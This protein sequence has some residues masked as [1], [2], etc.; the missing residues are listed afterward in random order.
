VVF[1]FDR[2]PLICRARVRKLRSL[3]PGVPI[4]GLYGGPGGIRET[5]LRMASRVVIGLDAFFATGRSPRWNWQHG[6]LALAAWFR[7]VGHRHEFDVVHLIEWDL[8]LLAPLDDLYGGVPRGALGLTAYTPLREVGEDWDWMR[9]GELSAGS[10][11]LLRRARDTWGFNQEPYACLFGAACFP[12]SFLAAYSDLDSPEV[13][14]DELRVPLFAAILGFPVQDTGFRRSWHE[15]AEDDAYF[16]AFG[17]EINP[18]TVRSEQAKVDG[19]RVFHPV[20]Q[21]VSGAERGRPCRDLR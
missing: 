19:R 12:R 18:E 15:G 17:R 16:N 7:E 14:H 21:V 3:N 1:R 6:D 20:R 13:G 8:L 10:E 11:E 5:A 9:L 2:N 4:F